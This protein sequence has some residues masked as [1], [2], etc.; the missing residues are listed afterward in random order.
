MYHYYMTDYYG[1]NILAFEYNGGN[2][3][4]GGYNIQ[5]HTLQKTMVGGGAVGGGAVGGSAVG[6]GSSIPIGLINFNSLT[7]PLFKAFHS[8]EI[9][10]HD[11]YDNLLNLVSI[12]PKKVSIKN[13]NYMNKS[14]KVKKT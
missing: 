7:K 14:R 8:S 11:I 10:S 4:A 9:L 6:G 3:L 13:R 1:G 5:S 2:I 12:N